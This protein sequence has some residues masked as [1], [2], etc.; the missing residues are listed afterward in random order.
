MAAYLLTV[1]T[2]L[3]VTRSKLGLFLERGDP[4]A[5]K[6]AHNQYL[7]LTLFPIV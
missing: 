6:D 3:S 7:L 2:P 1:A 5:E 4:D